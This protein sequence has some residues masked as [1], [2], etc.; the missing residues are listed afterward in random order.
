[1][2]PGPKLLS[3]L[4]STQNKDS[5]LIQ[6]LANFLIKI[7]YNINECVNEYVKIIQTDF[8]RAN[9]NESWGARASFTFNPSFEAI[10]F[11][12]K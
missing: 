8:V 12:K 7:A 4:N 5:V 10:C 1:M 9:I 3:V 11:A 6:T 2:C